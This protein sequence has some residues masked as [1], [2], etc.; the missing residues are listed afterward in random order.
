M[1]CKNCGTENDNRNV[2]KKCGEFVYQKTTQRETNP[3]VLK[4]M[5]RKRWKN[6]GKAMLWSILVIVGAFVVL[7]ILMVVIMQFITSKMDWPTEE[8]LQQELDELKEE[9]STES[10]EGSVGPITFIPPNNFGNL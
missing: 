1:I 10:N 9:Q 7:T 2:C 6:T 3:K 5:R 4:E 8:E